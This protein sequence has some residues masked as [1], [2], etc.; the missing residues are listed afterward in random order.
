MAV[1]VVEQALDVL[2]R[3]LAGVLVEL[4]VPVAPVE[5]PLS[6]RLG[7]AQAR[8]REARPVSLPV[9]RRSR[10]DDR[11]VPV[12]DLRFYSHLLPQV[13]GH[14]LTAPAADAQQVGLGHGH[15]SILAVR[16]AR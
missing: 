7:V 11:H 14:A 8:D 5:A 3:A 2:R 13:L 6:G 4:H 15:A 10:L 12:S 1:D 9:P 16:A